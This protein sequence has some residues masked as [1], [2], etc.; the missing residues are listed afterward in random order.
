MYE[1]VTIFAI[2]LP[3]IPRTHSETMLP[4]QPSGSHRTKGWANRGRTTSS[5]A[6]VCFKMF[7]KQQTRLTQKIHTQETRKHRSNDTTSQ[8]DNTTKQTNKQTNKQTKRQTNEQMKTNKH[9]QHNRAQ[10]NTK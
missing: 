9:T 7:T 8:N 2:S 6:N 1:S 10:H 3:Y 5:K 4:G